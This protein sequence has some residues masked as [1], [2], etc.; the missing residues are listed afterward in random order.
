M[1]LTYIANV[2]LF[3]GRTVKSK[4]GVLVDGDRIALVGPHARA[5]RRASGTK[6]VDGAGK[7]LGPGLI[8]C[9]VHLAFDGLADFAGEAEQMTPA[10]AAVKA[11]VNARKHLVAGVTTVRDLGGPGGAIIDVGRAIDDGVIQ[12]PRVVAAG[13][14]LTVTGGHGHNVAF[15][16]EVDGAADMRKAV[17]EEIRRGATAIKIV[18]TGG[19][20][21]PGIGAT[22]TAYTPEELAAAVDEAH[23]W[24]RPV[25]A[26]AIGAEGILRAVVAGVDSVEHCNMVTPEIAREMKSRGTYRSP[27][28][29]AI[30]GIVD[31]PAEVPAYAVEKGRA[32]EADSRASHVRAV[33][34]GVLHVCGTDAGT[35]FNPHGSAPRE[36]AYMVEWG[37]TPLAAMRAG[38]ANGAALLRRD[39]LGMVETGRLAD[40]VLYAANPAEDIAAAA[41]PLTVWKAGTVVRP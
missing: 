6:S 10:L 34:A 33:K 13:H 39:D 1:A 35:P 20:L 26:H 28:L 32:I 4:Q 38:T 31:N 7:T 37:M 30:R 21:T 9:H 27:T 18:A 17:R 14:A 5:P 25:A 12:G 22:F 2:T 23:G 11:T 40:L 15:G 8:D 19:V 36:L 29:C 41:V 3:D 24:G 16:R